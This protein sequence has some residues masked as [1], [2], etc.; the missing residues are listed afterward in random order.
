MKTAVIDHYP[1]PGDRGADQGPFLHA[2]LK[3]LVTGG[4]IFPGDY[5]TDNFIDKFI[6][7]LFQWFHIAADPAELT[8]TAGLFLVGIVE[9][10][11]V[12]NGFPIGHLGSAY[13][14]FGVVLPLHALDIDLKMQLAHA[15]DNRF[16][17]LVVDI[18]LEGR[19]LLGK[20]V[21][22]L[23]H[24]ALGLVVDRPDGQ[25]NHRGRYV[26]GTHGPVQAL[27][28]EGVSG[29]TV[30]PEQGDNITGTGLFYLFHFIGMEPHQPTNFQ[31]FACPGIDNGVTLSDNPLIGPYVGQ[32]SV[33]AVLEL[34]G[35]RHQFIIGI[36]G[37]LDLGLVIVKIKGD[38][39]H[40]QGTGKIGVNRVEK[41]LH[42]FILVR[43][44]QHDRG[45]FQRQGALADG[46]MNH[47]F[48]DFLFLEH[49]LHQLVG[50]HGNR[51]EQF[52]PFLLRLILEMIRNFFIANL[53]PLFTIKIDRLHGDKVNHAFHIIFQADGNLEH[54]CVQIQLVTQLLGNAVGIGAGSVTLV[55]KGDPG[56][57]VAGH[58]PING[59]RL[60]LYP[61]DRTE[62]QDSAV[63]H[64]QGPLDLNGEVNV[65]GRI[66]DIYVM[67]L[68]VTEGGSGLNGD[69]AFLFQ[70]HGI[71][72]RAD[73]IF[74][75][76]FMN[77]MNSLGVIENTLGKRGLARIYMGAY[78]YITYL[79]KISFHL[80]FLNLCTQIA[81]LC[82]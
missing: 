6:F 53:V 12:G 73:A 16:V 62:N 5:A 58:L 71:H 41:R 3:A 46:G 75:A 8:G 57:V 48:G 42:S 33:S 49:G 69:T 39:F 63:K 21:Q 67:A 78:S 36:I 60:G 65:A 81:A 64:P 1:D 82:C 25:G 80:A 28:T 45:K 29:G 43:R 20:P 9:L 34:E 70:L 52:F 55:D 47:L 44:S 30:N 76:Y 7:A 27:T 31:F 68:P 38:I 37:H 54:D 26:H 11:P 32:L 19:V 18:G 17:G 40:I 4:Y 35:K 50:K 10:R 15:G 66:N 22:G 61:T 79:F 24:I 77:G 56:N 59:D 74:S 2:R 72:G 13:F 51:V 14:H 23:G